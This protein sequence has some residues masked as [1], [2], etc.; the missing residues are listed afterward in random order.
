MENLDKWPPLKRQLSARVQTVLVK[1]F[2][3]EEIFNRP[4]KLASLGHD[5]FLTWRN[6]GRKSA[7]EL[8]YALESLGFTVDSGTMM[9]DPRS[10]PFLKMGRRILQKYFD[11]YL[12]KTLDDTEYIPV[13]RLI[14]EGISEEMRSAGMPGSSCDEVAD[15]LK[16]FNR[17]LYQ[18]VWIEQAKEDHDL[19]VD[20][21]NLEKEYQLAQDTFDYIYE[22]GEHPE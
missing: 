15:K 18:N 2:G 11:Y 13:G 1:V 5:A 12:R 21:L 14:I 19:D 10:E 9:T 3:S 7:R 16:A 20:P 4:E 6:L 8:V 17:S 22:H